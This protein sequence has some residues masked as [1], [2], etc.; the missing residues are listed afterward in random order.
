MPSLATTGAAQS[1]LQTR[2]RVWCRY[3]NAYATRRCR[4]AGMGATSHCRVPRLERPSTRDKTHLA[5]SRIWRDGFSTRSD[6]YMK[7]NRFPFGTHFY[8]S[9]LPLWLA[10]EASESTNRRTVS[11][12]I[13]SCRPNLGGVSPA[14]AV[15]SFVARKYA[16]KTRSRHLDTCTNRSRDRRHRPVQKPVAFKFSPARHDFVRF[17]P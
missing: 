17:G 2:R 4:H 7:E 11:T 16:K 12:R 9:R 8:A 1:N 15:R 10:M 3:E 14:V 6:G 5:D 13:G